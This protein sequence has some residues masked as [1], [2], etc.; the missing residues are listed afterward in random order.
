MVGYGPNILHNSL[1]G[2]DSVPILQLMLGEID[3]GNYTSFLYLADSLFKVCFRGGHGPRIGAL[4]R[5]PRLFCGKDGKRRRTENVR[6]DECKMQLSTI[7]KTLRTSNSER[8]KITY[9]ISVR[10]KF[11]LID[12]GY[13]YEPK[14]VLK[15]VLRR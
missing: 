8:G 9:R 7:P 15:H 6:C 12:V 3:F 5:L 10:V 4:E 13:C 2:A 1:L 11:Y 14:Y